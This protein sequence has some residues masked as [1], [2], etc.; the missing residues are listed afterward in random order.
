MGHLR[1]LNT[2][3]KRYC[4]CLFRFSHSF[5][6]KM[7]NANINGI[8]EYCDKVKNH[9]PWYSTNNLTLST[10][11]TINT[12]S[13]TNIMVKATTVFRMVRHQL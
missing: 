1:A 10:A 13:S 5:L 6:N 9:H 11:S 2:M 7:D 3:M 8:P 12:M 4:G